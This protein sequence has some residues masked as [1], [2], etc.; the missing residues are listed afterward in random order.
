MRTALYLL[1]LLGVFCAAIGIVMALAYGL[2]LYVAPIFK[3][4]FGL[5]FHTSRWFF[6]VVLLTISS[7]LCTSFYSLAKANDDNYMIFLSFALISNGFSLAVQLF[8]MIVHGFA[9][10][11]VELAGKSGDIRAVQL[12]SMG[13]LVFTLLNFVLCLSILREEKLSR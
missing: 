1:L 9:W 13:F 6:F 4:A 10:I 3:D 8:R 7:G 12:L 11:G 5:S 2:F